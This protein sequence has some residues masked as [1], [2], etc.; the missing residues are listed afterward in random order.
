MSFT[1]PDVSTMNAVL[2]KP[3]NGLLIVELSPAQAHAVADYIS[4]LTIAELMPFHPD[5]TV[6]LHRIM[7]SLQNHNEIK[8]KL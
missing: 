6:G 4:Q 3:D 7:E 5:A 1:L 8:E 2:D